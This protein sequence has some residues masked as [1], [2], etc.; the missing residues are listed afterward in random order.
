[1]ESNQVDPQ[2]LGTSVQG[3]RLISRVLPPAVR[4]WIHTQLDRVDELQFQL[5]GRDRQLLKGYVPKVSVSAARAIYQGVHLSQVQAEAMEIRINLGQVLR[6]KPLRLLQPFPVR[7]QL[8]MAEADLNAS[9]R[10]PL[11][12]QALQDLIQQLWTSRGCSPGQ[13]FAEADVEIK[14]AQIKLQAHRLWLTMELGEH[15]LDLMAGLSVREGRILVLN[16]P[17]F[18]LGASSPLENEPQLDD[19]EIDLGAEV[20]IEALR[21][22]PEQ[23][24]LSGVIQVVPG[25]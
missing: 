3:S 2:T 23:L 22:A 18:Q 12:L 11:L 1:M 25:D 9:L 14:S 7:G 16:Q 8:S 21:L 6:G 5:S 13:D 15:T 10:S 20:T 19:F 17:S 4:F 24:E